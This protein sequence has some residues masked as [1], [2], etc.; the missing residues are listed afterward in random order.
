MISARTGEPKQQDPPLSYAPVEMTL[1][2]TIWG[3]QNNPAFASIP[4][5]AI[6]H[7]DPWP[8]PKVVKDHESRVGITPAGVKALVEANLSE[9]WGK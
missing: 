7:H 6:L 2:K 1:L 3:S 9:V 8:S 5:E 4:C